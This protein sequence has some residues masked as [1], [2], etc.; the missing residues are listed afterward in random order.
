MCKGKVSARAAGR[1]TAIGGD[2][3][4]KLSFEK[5]EESQW[6]DPFVFVS[7]GASETG[8]FYTEMPLKDK[9]T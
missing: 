6:A 9:F 2:L 5:L 1:Q 7:S 8:Q 4:V 3:K